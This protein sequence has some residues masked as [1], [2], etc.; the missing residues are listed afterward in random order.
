MQ[1]SS[2]PR[3]PEPG[4]QT[5]GSGQG[6]RRRDFLKTS[7]LAALGASFVNWRP[8]AGPFTLADFEQLVPSDKR[9]NPEWVRSLTERGQPDVWRG[10][11]L[12]HIGLPIG[13]VGC[14]QLYL[15]GDGRLWSWQ[16]FKP[17]YSTDY[18]DVTAGPHYAHP[19]DAASAV[20]QG[21]GLR[22]SAEGTVKFKELDSRGFSDIRFRG[23]Y[24]IGRVQYREAGCPVAVDLEAFSPFI[25][26]DPESSGLPATLL[27]FTI[28]N[29][30]ANRI[31][32]E[33]AGWLQNC[34]GLSY[35]QP[36]LGVRRNR[37][38][39]RD[40][41]LVLECS[42]VVSDEL[43]SNKRLDRLPGYGTMA[44]ALLHS[45][46]N[47][48][49]AAAVAAPVGVASAFS[50]LRERKP[51]QSVT[52]PFGQPLVGALDRKL[53]LNPNES[54]QVTFLLTWYF[55]AYVNPTGELAAITEISKLRRHYV[56]HFISAADVTSHVARH[57]ESLAAQTRLWNRTWYDSTLPYWFLDRTFIP[58]DTLATTTCHWF[59]SGRFYG[60]EGVDCCPGTCQ[61]VWQ[62]AQAMGRI[63][64]Q[65]ERDIRER[66]DFGL[67]WHDNGA[68]DYRGESGRNVAHDGFA[69]TILRAYREHQT[70]SDRTFL[71][72]LW[73]RVRR[74]VEYL[75]RQD[76]DD[77]G[78]LEGEQYNTLDSSWFGPM[79]WI[80]SLY[81]AALQAGRQMALEMD[82]I[83]FAAHCERIIAAGR[84]NIVSRLFNGEYFIHKPD[85][86][87]PEAINTN[88]GCHIDQVFGQS[89]A[90]QLG[91]E[92]II[93]EAE[94]RAALGSLWR[95]NFTP[96]VGP[97]RK[98][99]KVIKGG[100]WYAMPG[101]GGLLMCT[102][103][104]GGAEKAA[105]TG[106]PTF[107]G[108]FNECMTGFEYQ[109]AAHM[110]W[111]G[112]VREGL[113]ITRSIHDRYHA[114][115]RNP[116][117]EV[118]CSDHYSRA[119]MSYGVF[120]AVCGY[121]YHGPKAHLGFAPRL[122]PADFRA[123]FT[124][125]EGWGTFSQK[126]DGT[127]QRQTIEVK[128]GSIRLKTLAF[129]LPNERK[130]SECKVSISDNP[131]ERSFLQRGT[132]IVLT[133]ESDLLLKPGQTLEISFMWSAAAE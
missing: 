39:R 68:M 29:V 30:S 108:Y 17:N 16:I 128:W 56:K 118:E 79:G 106:N 18:A 58:I 34:V 52:T 26:L 6:L 19:L 64:P 55:P 103:P 7:G 115:K 41:A 51:V 65:L 82:D 127:S 32:V 80:S 28:K 37:L 101:E 44:L 117:N 133:L 100:R 84:K 45:Q 66:V 109:V 86:K 130:V 76:G 87:H 123:P 5:K 77:N 12:K 95:Y 114:A 36:A 22:I 97:Y 31:E 99:F 105:G 9:L 104:K 93:P 50:A 71:A 116:Y 48:V 74:S 53:P 78:L 21:F 70:S 131:L 8:M 24:P 49:G 89:Y 112:L 4:D 60:W 132:R 27:Q 85:P 96:D 81:L 33:I 88:I 121:E 129:A 72:R 113:A 47:D 98:N 90:W 62:Y 122:T 10:A 46:R 124:A 83:D 94:C 13:G 54:G 91:L 125:A 110:I 119:M 67:A 120:L 126:R 59:D 69:G 25:A 2:E 35:D 111:E 61:H 15:G 40:G 43:P 73:P 1:Q 11:E 63:F 57:F 75:I 102:W 14:G 20:Q 107:V 92:R 3:L 23:E 38:F 42:A